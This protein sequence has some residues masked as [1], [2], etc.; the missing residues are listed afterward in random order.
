MRHR[1][2]IGAPD[3]QAV[4]GVTLGRQGTR[5]HHR[6]ASLV[7]D[8]ITR[9]VDHPALARLG[10]GHADLGGMGQRLANRGR[11]IAPGPA[12]LAHL[13]RERGHRRRIAQA[14]PMGHLALAVGARPVGHG[15][16]NAT[17]ELLDRRDHRGMLERVRQP[18]GLKPE[19]AAVDAARNIDRKDQLERAA[20]RRAGHDGQPPGQDERIA[21]PSHSRSPGSCR[22]RIS[23][24]PIS[25]RSLPMMT[26]G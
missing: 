5:E 2:R 18:V 13:G 1:V 23:S 10:R 26:D 22:P 20:E 6:R 4:D 11:E 19:L 3:H 25:R 7:G 24:W 16:Q 12:R 9:D 21:E 8:A 17:V 14:P 15:D